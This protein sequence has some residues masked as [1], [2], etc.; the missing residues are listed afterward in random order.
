MQKGAIEKEAV[1]QAHLDHIIAG[2]VHK[3]IQRELGLPEGSPA[4]DLLQLLTLLKDMEAAEEE[5]LL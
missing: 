3:S 2:A 4:P 5:V 1:N